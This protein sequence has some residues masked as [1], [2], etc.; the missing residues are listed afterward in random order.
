M[1]ILT[2]LGSFRDRAV[3]ENVRQY[4]LEEVPQRNKFIPISCLGINRHAVPDMWQWYLEHVD[5]L[6]TF[7][8]IHYERVIQA[9]VPFCCME[10]EEEARQFF[11][12]YMRRSDRARDVI[13]LSLEKLRIHVRMRAEL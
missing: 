7:H 9:I 11:D 10:K 2:A 13:K 5:V 3:I 1:I 12:A 8:P 6:E 4:A